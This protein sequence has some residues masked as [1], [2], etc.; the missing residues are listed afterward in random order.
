MLEKFVFVLGDK[1]AKYFS[2]TI[3]IF[4]VA[5]KPKSKKTI[6]TVHAYAC[7]L[8]DFWQRSFGNGLTMTR[9]AV[10]Y[11]INKIVDHY[12]NHVY[13]YS[14]QKASNNKNQEEKRAENQVAC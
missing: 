12:Y 9:N 6:S 7:S 3:S 2:V 13:G 5:S 11:K 1:L 4:Q 10:M 8:I 14:H